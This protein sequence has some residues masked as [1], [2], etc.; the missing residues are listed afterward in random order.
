MRQIIQYD[1]NVSGNS[2]GLAVHLKVKLKSSAVKKF[3]RVH[4]I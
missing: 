3:E 4:K 1:V 2:L